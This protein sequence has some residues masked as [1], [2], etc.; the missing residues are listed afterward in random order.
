MAINST[1]ELSGVYDCSV[2][3]ADDGTWVIA[4]LMDGTTVCGKTSR[5]SFISGVTYIFSG[6]YEIHPTY[7]QQFK[8]ETFAQTEP[9][10]D[11]EV[12]SYLERYLF[13]AKVGIGAGRARRLITKFGPKEVLR[14]IKGNPK[15]VAEV[16]GVTREQADTAAGIL[17]KM[18]AFEKTT[19][20]LAQAFKGRGF[21]Q[22]VIDMAIKDMGVAAYDVVDRD[23]FTLLVRGY[24]SAGFQRCDKMYRDLDRPEKRLK[25]QMICLWDHIQKSGGSTWVATSEATDVL[26]RLVTTDVNPEKAVELGIRAR[27]FRQREIGGVNYLAVT[28]DAINEEKLAGEIARLCRWNNG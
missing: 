8:F 23:P 5:S 12:M 24:P 14:Q 20:K 4:K 26:Q 16:T 7:G 25:R 21:G 27:W 17:I 22:N 11:S 10:T 9:A 2:F 28:Q 6:R 13:N 19:M 18:E 15:A 3:S 1:I